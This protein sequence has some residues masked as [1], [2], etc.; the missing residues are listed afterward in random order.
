MTGEDAD[1]VETLEITSWEDPVAQRAGAFVQ[2]GQFAI[3]CADDE[4]VRSLALSMLRKLNAS[5]KTPPE[6]EL[7]VISGG[8]P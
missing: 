2:V 1:E 5:I 3:S 6:A 4:Q 8:K 7:R